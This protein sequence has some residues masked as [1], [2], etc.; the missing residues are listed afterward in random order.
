MQSVAAKATLV[1]SSAVHKEGRMCAAMLT[2]PK[3]MTKE[4]E[5]HQ[6]VLNQNTSSSRRRVTTV[7][8][9]LRMYVAGAV[10]P[11][12]STQ[13]LGADAGPEMPPITAA[14]HSP[15]ASHAARHA[16]T[17]VVGP[18]VLTSLPTPAALSRQ[19][20]YAP[21][22][23]ASALVLSAGLLGTLRL[24]AASAE[25][26]PTTALKAM[27]SLQQA[28]Q[29]SQQQSQHMHARR[30][31]TRVVSGN[32]SGWA[33]CCKQ[34]VGSALP[35]APTAGYM[36][37]CSHN[38]RC[39]TDRGGMSRQQQQ[40]SQL[41]TAGTDRPAGHMQ[42]KQQPLRTDLPVPATFLKHLVVWYL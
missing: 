26:P 23:S 4:R 29:Q 37:V 40:Q 2:S 18:V 17:L 34:A 38:G 36:F 6:S 19:K 22:D 20:V 42:H 35:H 9:I 13:L 1:W 21:V 14:A 15:L 27:M 25:R 31:S 33:H 41:V 3:G 10:L 24:S 16:R 7:F 12:T 28:Q 39:G 5:G 8:V 32:G 11:L 30:V